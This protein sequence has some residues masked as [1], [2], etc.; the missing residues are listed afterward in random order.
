MTVLLRIEAPHYVAGLVMEGINKWN[1]GI[2]RCAPIVYWMKKRG[3]GL[4]DV[5][6]YC[7]RKGFVCWWRRVVG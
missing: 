3:W 6:E 5:L 1:M 2:A 7:D 4:E